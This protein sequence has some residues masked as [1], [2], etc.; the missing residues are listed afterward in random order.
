MDISVYFEPI[1]LDIIQ[2]GET[3][4]TSQLGR[5]LLKHTPELGFPSCENV[6]LAILG[7]KEDRNSVNN[8]GCAHAP[9]RVREELYKLFQGAYALNVVDLGN[10]RQGHE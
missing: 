2:G 7:V 4:Q 5:V 8:S 9:N 6:Q 1:D 10:I 3:Y